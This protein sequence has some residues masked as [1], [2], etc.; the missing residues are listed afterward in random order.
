MKKTEYSSNLNTDTKFTEKTKRDMQTL[1]TR[2][3][4]SKQGGT[5]N[6]F[7]VTV[8]LHVHVTLPEAV[9]RDTWLYPVHG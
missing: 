8:A 9:F 4:A 1:M 6:L 3:S 5:S 7:T 2:A